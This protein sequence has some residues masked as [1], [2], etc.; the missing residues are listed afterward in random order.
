MTKEKEKAIEILEEIIDKG[1]LISDF[2]KCVAIDAC[3]MGI[4]AIKQQTEWIPI[5][6]RLP[7][8]GEYILDKP[9]YYLVQDEFGDMMVARYTYSEYWV[10][11]DR[12]KAIGSDIIAWRELPVPYKPTK[13]LANADQSGLEYADNPTV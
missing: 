9:K 12:I 7:K 11:I 1:W 6:E 4:E 3:E 5:T 2:E 8:P 10:Q 13:K